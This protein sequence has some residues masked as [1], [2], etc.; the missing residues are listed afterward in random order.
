MTLPSPLTH[1]QYE[2]IQERLVGTNGFG[3]LRLRDGDLIANYATTPTDPAS[4]MAIDLAQ[5]IY[6]FTVTQQH[7]TETQE[8]AVIRQ[9]TAQSTRTK[10]GIRLYIL[11]PLP[12]R[13][14]LEI[15]VAEG[16]AA[17]YSPDGPSLLVRLASSVPVIITEGP[18]PVAA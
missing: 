13:A 5:A 17:D 2:A 3:G 4:L 8:Q 14:G 16:T 11:A 12:G 18:A 9:L 10:T 1:A 7:Y 15:C 6:P